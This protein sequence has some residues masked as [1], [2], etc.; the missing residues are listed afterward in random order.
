MPLTPSSF[1]YFILKEKSNRNYLL[2]AGIA[3]IAQ[4]II[5]K[6]LYPYA[7]FFSDSY[8]YIQAAAAHYDVSIWPIGSYGYSIRSPIQIPR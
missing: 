6:L 2:I 5:F 8:S 7:D 1:G 3:C 4:L